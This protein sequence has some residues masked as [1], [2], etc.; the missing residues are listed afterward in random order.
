MDWLLGLLD[1]ASPTENIHSLI[2]SSELGQG[3][4]WG[5]FCSS[6]LVPL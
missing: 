6:A 1:T 3:G 2:L 5:V 4:T